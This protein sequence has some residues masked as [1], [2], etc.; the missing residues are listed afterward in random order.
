M[1][2]TMNVKAVLSN[3]STGGNPC[4]RL[5]IDGGVTINQDAFVT[6]YADNLRLSIADA[7]YAVDKFFAT[8]H[9]LVMAN[10]AVELEFMGARLVVKGSLRSMN[11]QP[12]KDKNPVVLQITAKGRL[13][14][15]LAEIVLKNVTKMVDAALHEIMQNGASAVSRIENAN[16][17]VINGKGLIITVDNEDEGV[18]LE[19]SGTVVAE[20]E[21]TYSDESKII[22]EFGELALEN[23]VYDLCV[24]TRNGAAKSAGISARRLTRKITV[25]K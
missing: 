9:E 5:V 22:A 4:Y 11:Q 24:A 15:S 12:T 1:A 23:G 17:I 20:A 21:V 6:R 8:L 2:K 18:W 7:R 25:A 19:K 3:L 10:K 16:A 14:D 13:A